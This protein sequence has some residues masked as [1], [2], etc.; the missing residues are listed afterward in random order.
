[1]IEDAA[2]FLV[3]KIS[4]F[5]DNAVNNVGSM[6]TKLAGSSYRKLRG[7]TKDG[8]NIAHAVGDCSITLALK[9]VSNFFSGSL[10]VIV[11]H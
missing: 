1:M 9:A 5:S 4:N 6:T 10:V 11:R 7:I 2:G 3:D 8:G